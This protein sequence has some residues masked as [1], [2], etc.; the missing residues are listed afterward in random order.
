MH[1]RAFLAGAAFAGL[2]ACSGEPVWAPQ[3]VVSAKAFRG[4]GPKS[5]TLYT[6]KNTGSGNGA[7][8]ALLVD[9]S[10]RVMFDPAGTFG[11][12]TIPERNDVLFGFSPQVEQ[13]YA[14]YHAR[15]SFYIVSQK[16][17]VSPQVA[18]RAL[19]LVQANGPVAK[20]NCTRATSAILRQLPGFGG[21]SQTWFPNSLSDDFARLPGVETREYR[22][23][24]SDDKTLAAR[25]VD[26]QIRAAQ[27]Q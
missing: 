6:M 12:P 13:Y 19:Q 11:H 15:S 22:E 10:Q 7:H 4:T 26:M 8:T 24:D 21:L 5:L 25:Q 23:N 18:E 14:S 3:E 20:A 2:A 16:V 1:R 27:S 17:I 9:A